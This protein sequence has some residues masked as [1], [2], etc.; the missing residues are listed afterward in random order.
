MD[1]PTNYF[2]TC[3]INYIYNHKKFA[4]GVIVF[5]ITLTIAAVGSSVL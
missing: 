4:K 3:D 1:L 5:E 2:I